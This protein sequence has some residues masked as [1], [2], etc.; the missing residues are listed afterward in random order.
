MFSY[1][2]LIQPYDALTEKKGTFEFKTLTVA[3][4][5]FESEKYNLKNRTPIIA[6]HGGPAFTRLY[7]MPIKKVAAMGYPVIM[8]D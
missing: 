6:I 7:M 1:E 3:Y 2:D 5:V 4:S 8:Y